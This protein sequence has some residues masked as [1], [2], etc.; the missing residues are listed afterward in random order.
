MSGDFH[1]P[2]SIIGQEIARHAQL[3]PPQKSI[4]RTSYGSLIMI[5]GGYIAW[6]LGPDAI[7]EYPPAWLYGF[8]AVAA[9]GLLIF[10]VG[11]RGPRAP[12]E[13][14][15]CFW[16]LVWAAAF[17]TGSYALAVHYPDWWREYLWI[18]CAC[19]SFTAAQG[20]E[21]L[22]RLRPVPGDAFGMVGRNIDENEFRWD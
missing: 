7:H 5:A 9:F 11:L 20:L 13:F 8:G 4:A 6:S 1:G 18:R 19:I 10:I 21:F 16:S 14:M 2:L 22:L 17:G 3:P 15:T 12:V